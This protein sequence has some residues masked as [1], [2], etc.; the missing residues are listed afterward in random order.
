MSLADEAV[1]EVEGQCRARTGS[2][3]HRSCSE[4]RVSSTRDDLRYEP[5]PPGRS[6]AWDSAMLERHVS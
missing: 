1:G 4:E 3:G 6:E 2:S 5:A